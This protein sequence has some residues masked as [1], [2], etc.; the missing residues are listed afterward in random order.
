MPTDSRSLFIEHRAHALVG[1]AHQP[2]GGTVEI[3]LASGGS[4]DAH[5]VFDGAALHAIPFADAAVLLR[6]KFGHHEQADAFD[7]L[8]CVGQARQHQVNDVFGQIVFAGGDE[9]L[10]TAQ[11]IAAIGS[12]LRLGAQ[13][14]EIGAAMGLGQTHGAGPAAIHQFRQ[15]QVLELGRAVALEREVGAV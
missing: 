3:H 12:R 11:A 7:A 9:N 15:V 8:G 1:L 10:R 13:Q 14:P 5:F 4:L 2:A 6:E